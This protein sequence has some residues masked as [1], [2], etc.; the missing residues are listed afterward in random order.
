MNR[1]ITIGLSMLAGAVLGAAAVQGLH[2]QSKAPVYYVSEIDITNLEAY[3]KDYAPKAQALTR[4]MGG[5]LLAAGENITTFEGAP[6]RTRITISAWE[7]F[8]KVK[9]W[10]NSADYKELRKTGDQYAK[11]RAFAVEGVAQ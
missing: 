9:A 5:R 3:T 7:S 6:P 11:F 1:S 8:D 10:R 4:A 2:A